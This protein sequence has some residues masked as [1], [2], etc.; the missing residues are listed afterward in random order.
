MRVMS[1]VALVVIVAFGFSA[2]PLLAQPNLQADCPMALVSNH[3]ATSDFSLSPHGVFRSNSQVFVLRG[4]TLSTYNV[5]D[6]GDFE[7]F[8]EAQ[9]GSMAARE[10]TGGTAFSNGF[11]FVSSE[12]GLEIFDLRGIRPGPTVP[13]LVSRTPGLHYHQLAVS[14]N[15]LAALFPI[16]DMPCYPNG[17]S[18]CFNSVD[19]FDITNMN[20]PVMVGSISSLQTR[21]FLGWNDIAFN[22]GFLFITGEAGT[23]GFNI[24]DPVH[25]LN[26][27]QTGIP[28]KFLISNGTN[29]LAVG[30]DSTISI[31]TVGLNGAITLFQTYV[32]PAETL[33]RA[34]PIVF[35]REGF[36]DDQ[37]GRMVTMIDE[38]D[39]ETLKPARTIAI[40]VFDFTVPLYEG[41]YERIYENVSYTMPDEVKFNPLAAGSYVY[42]VGS[43]SGLQAY[44][45]CGTMVGKIEWDGTAA[46]NCGSAEIRGWITGAQKIANVEVL[47]DNGSLGTTTVGGVPRTDV[48][49][50][51]PVYTWHLPFD[52]SVLAQ[53]SASPTIHTLRAIG[54]DAFGNRRQFASQRFVLIQGANC[55]NRRRA[56]GR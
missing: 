1:R 36:I 5:T 31:Y 20:A 14:G 52:T 12:A 38:L 41:A 26:L 19:L 35:H 9:I 33:D 6:T 37:N 55:T 3:A 16:I 25:P 32:I 54:T 51:T 43:N 4:Q 17:S 34:N 53:S 27:G 28:G 49:S 23:V 18:F 7:P 44:G 40:D 10:T 50:R 29:L 24:S 56:A 22:Q 39:R 8:Q 13:P 2:F 30:N 11:L 45:A 42:V 15:I 47:L 21:S 46:F 48:S